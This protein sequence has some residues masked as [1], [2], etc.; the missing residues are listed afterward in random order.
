MPPQV[1]SQPPHLAETHSPQPSQVWSRK[2]WTLLAVLTI[3]AAGLRFYQLGALPPGFQFDEAYNAIDA[4]LVLEG[5]RPLFLPANAGREVL[6]T[7][8][9][10]ALVALFGLNVTTLRLASALLGTLA[11]PVTYLLYRRILQHHSRTIAAA[12]ALALAISLWHLHF[13]R[14]G[15]RV[16]SMP[17]L[18]SAAF[19]LAWLSAHGHSPRRRLLAALGAGLLTGLSVWT[20]PT[21]RLAPLVLIGFSLWLLWR[22]PKQRRLRLDS[23]LARLVIMGAAALAVFL[24]LGIEFYRHPEFFFSHASEVSVFAERVGGDSPWQ[25]LGENVLHIL[26]MFAFAG[27]REWTHNLAGRPVFDPLMAVVYAIGLVIWAMRL[28][29]RRDP[30]Q[31]AL[32]LLACWAI[33]M[34]LPSLL[35]DAAP[36]YSRMMPALPALFTAAGLGLDWLLHLRQ[37]ARWAGPV[38]VSL[39][40]VYS[41]ERTVGDYFVRFASQPAIYYMYDAD[42]LSALDYL[43]QFTGKN[44]V[45]LSYL[46]GDQ[47][48]TVNFLRG[49]LGIKSVDMVDTIVLPPPG[50]GAV[51]AF[52]AEQHQRAKELAALWNVS[53]HPVMDPYGRALLSIVQINADQAATWPPGLQ[54]T[55][56]RTAQFSGAPSLLGLQVGSPDNQVRLFWGSESQIERSLTTSVHLVDH[57][58]RSIGQVDRLPGNGTYPTSE[59]TPGERVIDRAY[60]T[61]QDVCAGGETVRVQVGWYDLADMAAPYPRS[62]APGYTALA[63]HLTLGRDTHPLS[64]F[65]P[66][67]RLDTPISP[68]LTLLGYTV[69]GD[70]L[71]PGSPMTVDLMWHSRHAQGAAS[72]AELEFALLSGATQQPLWSGPLAPGMEWDPDQGYCTRLRF[73]LS[74]DIAPGEV[75]LRLRW[76]VSGEPHTTE[77][78]RLTVGPSTR[79][80]DLPPL[81][82]TADG[83]LSEGLDSEI[84]LAGAAAIAQ[85]T[86]GSGD[87]VIVTLVWQAAAR[88]AGN[89]TVFVH[90]LDPDGRIVAQS[91]HV[92]AGDYDTNRWLPGEVVVDD[93]RLALP[94]HL[95]SGVYQVVA[96]MYE[97]IGG[98]R[99]QAASSDGEPL[100]EDRISLGNIIISP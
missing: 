76:T 82:R 17:V 26:G 50:Q 16:I 38:L 58:G 96:G 34:L 64:A 5:N 77:L 18:F 15:I 61:I 80:F 94:D 74:N 43:R 33:V 78:G 62:D 46:W 71:Q 92:P 9:Q 37:P 67:I 3:L 30:D 79:R 14:Y 23:P 59:W 55:R 27:D 84:R 86:A 65:E 87:S 75:P 60:P 8:F 20:H 63:G 31:D 4:K 56:T 93:H 39:I 19:G 72:P 69:H 52:P 21:G 45:Y 10:A 88:I 40:V 32:A 49:D 36:N 54:P 44:Q 22:H 24:P 70:D 2:D 85:E 42:K 51:Y 90:L 97:P 41:A 7:Y 68:T 91:D 57:D 11:V 99:L 12:T 95:A 53:A 13:S 35:S 47:H 81:A 98:R 83:L 28:R 1:T 6:Y 25:A 73:T 89:Y 29:P 48:A 100:P 66:Q